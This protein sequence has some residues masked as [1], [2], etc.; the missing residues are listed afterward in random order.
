ME[1]M[2]SSIRQNTDNAVATEEIANKSAKDADQSGVAVKEA[3]EAMR[4]IAEKIGIIEEIARQTNLLALNAAI[5]AARAGEHGKGFAVVAAE[6]R[7]LAERS[8]TA[9]GEISQLS[10][11]TMDVA[12][13]AGAMLDELVPNIRR[14]AELVQEISSASSEQ[15][16]GADQ[17]NRAITQLDAVIQQNAAAAEE[18][19]STS[20]ELTGQSEQLEQTMAFFKVNGNGKGSRHAGAVR[21]VESRPHALPG[22]GEQVRNGNGHGKVDMP[23][24]STGFDMDMRDEAEGFERF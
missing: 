4:H 7:K 17:I 3:V 9:A 15:N 19:A 11:S 8:G 12:E 22:G 21:V 10:T 1:Q 6:V 13:R 23:M 18:M 14:T 5:E 24:K 2:A 16:A 20:E